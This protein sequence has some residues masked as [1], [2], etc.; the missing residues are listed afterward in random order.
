MASEEGWEAVAVRN[1][2]WEGRKGG[3]D[4]LGGA[5]YASSSTL[6]REAAAQRRRSLALERGAAVVIGG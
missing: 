6:V 2:S 1:D 5:P 4:V 3:K